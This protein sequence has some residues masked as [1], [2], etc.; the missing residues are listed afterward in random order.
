MLGFKGE[1][2]A[3]PTSRAL[4]RAHHLVHLPIGR[5][6]DRRR[7][8]PRSPPPSAF[9][10]ATRRRSS[11][12]PGTTIPASAVSTSAWR[13]DGPARRKT[14]CPRPAE[15]PSC[16]GFPRMP[17]PK[18]WEYGPK[19][20]GSAGRPASAARRSCSPRCRMK[21][22]TASISMRRPKFPAVRARRWSTPCLPASPPGRRCPVRARRAC[23]APAGPGC[24]KAKY[25][26]RATAP[27]RT[28]RSSAAGSTNP[29]TAHDPWPGP[30]RPIM[31]RNASTCWMPP[32]RH[33]RSRA[34]RMR[35]CRVWPP[36]AGRRRRACTP[37][38]RTGKR[39]C[40]RRSTAI[41]ASCSTGPT[42]SA[43]R[44]GASPG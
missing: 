41:P 40:P 27:S 24:S 4:C 12:L 10:P 6:I 26:W 16:V 23:A 33:S 37:A 39:S 5:W 18:S 28:G 8:T 7:E 36:P 14:G 19:A 35:R 22:A 43:H 1:V 3:P 13:P 21:V 11:S 42:R 30:D 32:S 34:T 15:S 31:M 25:G 2:N 38:C 9:R 29:T 17:I 20:T 44:G